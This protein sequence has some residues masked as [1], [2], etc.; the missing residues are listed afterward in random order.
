MNQNMCK[1][2]LIES[3]PGSFPE[4]NEDLEQHPKYA[5]SLCN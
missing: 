1:K 3:F 5:L 2:F 4:Q